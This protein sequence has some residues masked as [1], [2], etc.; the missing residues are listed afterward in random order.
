[1]VKTF[2]FKLAHP[3]RMIMLAGTFNK[4]SERLQDGRFIWMGLEGNYHLCKDSIDL[5]IIHKPAVISWSIIESNL[6][7]FFK[8]QRF[9]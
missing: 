3:E 1:M 5:D 2:H 8:Q 4:K 9:I 6:R 7:K